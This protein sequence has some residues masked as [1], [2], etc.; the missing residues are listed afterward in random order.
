MEKIDQQILLGHTDYSLEHEGRLVEAML[1]RRPEAIVLSYDGHTDRTVE[2]LK[3]ANG[4]RHKNR[5]DPD[6]ERRIIVFGRI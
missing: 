5:A 3:D 6:R 4:S 2:L 1:R